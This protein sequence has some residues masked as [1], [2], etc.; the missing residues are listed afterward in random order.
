MCY[1][2]HFIM[3]RPISK[4][5][6]RPVKPCTLTNTHLRVGTGFGQCATIQGAKLNAVQLVKQG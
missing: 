3:K 5:N 6:R 1:A 4:A 2:T